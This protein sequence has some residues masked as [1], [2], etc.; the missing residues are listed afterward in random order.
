MRI[1]TH[2]EMEK[3][4]HDRLESDYPEQYV[5]LGEYWETIAEIFYKEGYKDRGER[6]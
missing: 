3:I 4:L 5:E 6:E 2:K 1:P